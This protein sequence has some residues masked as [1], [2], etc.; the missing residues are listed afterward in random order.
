MVLASAYSIRFYLV[1][2]FDKDITTTQHVVMTRISLCF[3]ETNLTS[4]Q[5][6]KSY[7]DGTKGVRQCTTDTAPNVQH[8][9]G[10]TYNGTERITN[11]TERAQQ[12]QR[13]VKIQCKRTTG[14]VLS[15]IAQWRSS[16]QR[17]TEYKYDNGETGCPRRGE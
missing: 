11:G 4:D 6:R 14:F 15:Q 5:K 7:E 1:V 9:P 16:A 10:R 2:I 3:L 13:K 17:R 12:Q 8:G